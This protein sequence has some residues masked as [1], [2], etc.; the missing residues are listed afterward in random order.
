MGQCDQNGITVS[1]PPDGNECTSDPA[2]NPATGLCSHPPVANGTPCSDTDGNLCTKAACAIGQCDQAYQT[3]CQGADQTILGSKLRVSDRKPGTDPTK[4]MIVGMGRETHSPNTIVGDPTVNGATLT[5]YA[6]GTTSTSQSYPLPASAG[7]PPR[8]LWTAIK[9]G[10]RYRDL[11]LT[12]GPVKT[13]KLTLTK[14]TFVLQATL[15]GKN[16]GVAVVPPNTG[17]DGC[18]LLE[19][20]RGDRYHVLLPGPPE[21]S[22]KKN[23]AKSFLVKGAAIQGTCPWLPDPTCCSISIE[24]VIPGCTMMPATQCV[25]AGKS[26]G[27]GVC[28]SDGTCGPAIGPGDCCDTAGQCF[29]AQQS[30]TPFVCAGFGTYY[31]NVTCTST[32]CQ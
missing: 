13:A 9:G 6:N 12:A 19:M 15:S 17:T 1:C 21:G 4:R 26:V 32:G 16:G 7:N 27:P 8:P 3:L 24:D 5:M 2:C 22:I 31:T 25:G 29:V 11:K 10:F 14:G 18:L 23:D 30:V 20:I 28:R